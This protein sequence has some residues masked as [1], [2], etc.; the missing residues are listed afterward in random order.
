MVWTGQSTSFAPTVV[1][2]VVFSAT[3]TAAVLAPPLVVISGGVLAGSKVRA[4]TPSLSAA[5]SPLQAT[6]KW[7]AS[8][9]ATE[10][11]TWSLA[12]LWLTRIGAPCTTPLALILRA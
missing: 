3:E 8:R 12:V 7:S 10:A 1:T 4:Y 9:T 5:E 2:A 11:A 6:T